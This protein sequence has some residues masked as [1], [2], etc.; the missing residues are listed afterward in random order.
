MNILFTS[1]KYIAA[2]LYSAVISIATV[3][4]EDSYEA[5]F[6]YVFFYIAGALGTALMLLVEKVEK[7]DQKSKENITPKRVAYSI[8]A[9]IAIVFLSGTVR[10][11]MIAD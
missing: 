9:C 2:M 10:A 8:V 3:Q 4:M 6:S 7:A 11:S 5:V 1:F